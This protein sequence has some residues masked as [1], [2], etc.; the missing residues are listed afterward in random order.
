MNFERRLNLEVPR[1]SLMVITMSGV[2]LLEIND[3]KKH[4][5]VGRGRVFQNLNRLETDPY[6]GLAI[7]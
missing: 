2:E 5:P 1:M 7:A 4:A 3:A 6:F